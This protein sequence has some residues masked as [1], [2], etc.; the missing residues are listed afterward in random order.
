[1]ACA[2][3][4]DPRLSTRGSSACSRSLPR[5]LSNAARI[6]TGLRASSRTPRPGQPLLAYPRRAPAASPP[7]QRLPGPPRWRVPSCP[8]SRF[9]GAGRASAMK[10]ATAA[11]P[12]SATGGS[13]QPRRPRRPAPRRRRNSRTS[14]RSG[15]P[16]LLSWSLCCNMAFGLGS[17]G[18]S[19]G[20]NRRAARGPCSIGSSRS[21]GQR[22]GSR[23]RRIARVAHPPSQES[24]GSRH[25]Q[26]GGY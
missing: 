24:H 22:R 9:A 18:L 26:T 15:S 23:F 21:A 11:R 3:G 10:T 13:R 17:S 6:P 16:V 25:R 12:T 14:T 7:C 20:P 19:G 2:Y 4:R 5:T 1:M 8:R